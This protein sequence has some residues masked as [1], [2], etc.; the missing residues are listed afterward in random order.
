MTLFGTEAIVANS[1]DMNCVN[2]IAKWLV[3]FHIRRKSSCSFRTEECLLGSICI[4]CVRNFAIL[5]ILFFSSF[6]LSGVIHWCTRR[7]KWSK[8]VMV[9]RLQVNSMSSSSGLSRELVLVFYGLLGLQARMYIMF[10]WML[11]LSAR[12]STI[13]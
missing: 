1:L 13:E 4:K 7:A 8:F 2:Q 10:L 5:M 11:Q 9:V 3:T 12:L 6:R